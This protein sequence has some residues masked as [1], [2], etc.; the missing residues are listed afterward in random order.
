MAEQE[1]KSQEVPSSASGDQNQITGKQVAAGRAAWEKYG[2]ESQAGYVFKQNHGFVLKVDQSELDQLGITMEAI[3]DC[4]EQLEAMGSGAELKKK[5]SFRKNQGFA[6]SGLVI[7]SKVDPRIKMAVTLH[8]PDYEHTDVL[9]GW[10]VDVENLDSEMKVSNEKYRP[11]RPVDPEELKSVEHAREA[12]KKESAELSDEEKMLGLT[13]GF[14]VDPIQK[15]CTNKQQYLSEG[16]NMKALM[17]SELNGVKVVD[18]VSSDQNK[19]GLHIVDPTVAQLKEAVERAIEEGYDTVWV[20]K[21]SRVW[22]TKTTQEVSE[23]FESVDFWGLPAHLSESEGVL[24]GVGS[25]SGAKKVGAEYGEMSASKPENSKDPKKY[26]KQVASMHGV[27]PAHEDEDMMHVSPEGQLEKPKSEVGKEYGEKEHGEE[28]VKVGEPGDDHGEHVMGKGSS[29]SQQSSVPASKVKPSN[30]SKD[31][32]PKVVGESREQRLAEARKARMEWYKKKRM[33]S[34]S[35]KMSESDAKKLRFESWKKKRAMRMSQKEDASKISD[36]PEH[37]MATMGQTAKAT[38][39]QEMK[40]SMLGSGRK[41]AM[42]RRMHR[43]MKSK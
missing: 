12:L 11:E 27:D 40:G 25:S 34:R 28:H 33:E 5:F 39:K 15:F 32:A 19:D 21:N 29:S 20:H 24:M 14:E 1:L 41:A 16:K 7:S 4:V 43:E 38:A 36:H 26:D 17:E 10:F 13:E 8:D 23:S 6:H 30:I 37:G 9:L 31:Q 35:G 3:L 22:S 42:G 2:K 18:A